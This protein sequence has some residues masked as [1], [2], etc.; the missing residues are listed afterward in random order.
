VKG[1]SLRRGD[2]GFALVDFIGSLVDQLV[3]PMDPIPT[4]KKKASVDHN[5]FLEVHKPVYRA[6]KYMNDENE[7]A[8]EEHVKYV[9]IM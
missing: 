4:N 6:D 5:R 2:K 1:C 3:T 8:V 9:A 7:N